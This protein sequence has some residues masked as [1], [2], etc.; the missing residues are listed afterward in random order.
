M[1]DRSTN[2][3][4]LNDCL[5][6]ISR[7]ARDLSAQLHP[8]LSLVAYS[9]LS[10]IEA[11]PN[12]RAADLAAAYGLD[13]STVSRQITQ[14][15]DAGLLVRTGEKPGRRGHVLR[16]TKIGTK[17][18]QRAM[19]SARKTLAAHLADWQDEDIEALAALLSRFTN[20]AEPVPNTP[21]AEPKRAVARRSDEFSRK[22]GTGIRVARRI[23]SA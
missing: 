10:F 21:A 11:A 14:L 13:K 17:A 3:N 7:Q 20:P 16:L 18:L 8:E 5:T 15:E 4:R 12:S 2:I 23:R 6:V 1:A 9:L 19:D 22:P